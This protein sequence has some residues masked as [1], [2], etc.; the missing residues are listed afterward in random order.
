MRLEEINFGEGTGVDAD[1]DSR[2]SAGVLITVTNVR[3]AR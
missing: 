2:I 1:D 3:A